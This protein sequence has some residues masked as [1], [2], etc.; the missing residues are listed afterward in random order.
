MSVATTTAQVSVHAVPVGIQ[1]VNKRYMSPREL[2]ELMKMKGQVKALKS[3]GASYKIESEV[4]ML[5][6]VFK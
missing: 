6:P 1:R 5:R 4:V 3:K 2:S